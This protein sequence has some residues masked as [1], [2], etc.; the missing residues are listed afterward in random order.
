MTAILAIIA[1]VLSII[2]ISR[3]T[4][5]NSK[6]YQLEKQLK[7]I[8]SSGI[9]FVP[10]TEQ[11]DKKDILQEQNTPQPDTVQQT[12]P[13]EQP[14]ILAET[15]PETQVQ[16]QAAAVTDIIPA[17]EKL[18][19]QKET[20]P[21][22][23]S[24]P[25]SVAQVFSWA[26]GILL[27]LGAF[28]TFSYLIQK[29]IITMPL[30]L[31]LSALLGVIL[32]VIGCVIKDKNL[33]TTASTLCAA[34]VSICFIT[35]YASYAFFNLID[36]ATAF[37]AMAITAF[38]SFVLSAVKDKQYIAFLALAAAFLTPCLLS[39]N[40]NKYIFFFSYLLVVNIS[41]I[42]IAIKKGWTAII[43]TAITTTFILQSYYPL[44][45]PGSEY[46]YIVYCVYAAI[47]CATAF[48]DT[49]KIKREIFILFGIFTSA[50]ILMLA[51]CIN[52]ANMPFIFASAIFVTI[53]VLVFEFFHKTHIVQG[54]SLFC[55]AA[56]Y[57]AFFAK[58]S[59]TPDAGYI[60]LGVFAIY[61]AY[62]MIFKNHFKDGSSQWFA[63]A[64]A[65]IMAII[66]LYSTL[67]K[68]YFK[69]I[70][71]IIPFILSLAYFIPS[72]TLLDR[73]ELKK[74]KAIFIAMSAILAALVIPIQFSG[75]W[76]T[77]LLALYACALCWL[78]TKTENKSF[79]PLA[80]ILFAVVFVRLVM[81]PMLFD[82]CA[83]GTKIFNW[84]LLLFGVSS[85]SMFAAAKFC[86]AKHL[87]FNN[88]LNIA[89]G[90]LLFALLNIEVADFYSVGG[91]LHFNL[92]GEFAEAVT[93]TLAWAISGAL[94]C[95]LA[96][97]NRNKDLS[98]VGIFLISAA[99]IKLG[100]LDLW[101]LD[102]IYRILG[103]FS[104]AVLL[105]GVAV[106]FQKS[107]KTEDA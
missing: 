92:A 6:I 95:L 24:K 64:A 35:A 28:F 75:K 16:T 26:G 66:P 20:A 11:T 39:T 88:I 101:K 97:F 89:G 52:N 80:Q 98:K 62:P 14:A 65:G 8:K 9:N 74:S 104:M 31:S 59:A 73:E 38:A 44:D 34:G 60:A 41:A 86:K 33:Q 105:I 81:N 103:V 99:L 68:I 53:L 56:L 45:N 50:Q 22:E 3:S 94:V 96:F 54:V 21:E 76:L 49:N 43:W 71:G 58:N 70:L 61:W 25:I 23:L 32:T 37:A 2:A 84:Y 91:K 18:L 13:T 83:S 79:I 17:Q 1:I 42:S 46:L 15:L 69:E 72:L 48:F 57:C 67:G 77:V 63:S 82:Y 90:L 55:W 30:I 10:Q 106:L 87:M 102:I 36:I 51:L 19:E 85:A 78:D 29:G 5:A 107:N 7:N 47:A 4:S 27:V 100:L 93:Y 12:I 40:E